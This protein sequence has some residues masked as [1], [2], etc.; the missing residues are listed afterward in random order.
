MAP[1]QE[2][3]AFIRRASAVAPATGIPLKLVTWA[4]MEVRL[5]SRFHDSS[6]HSILG[7]G[8]GIDFRLVRACKR[9]VLLRQSSHKH[10]DAT[11]ASKCTHIAQSI[12]C[13][14]PPPAFHFILQSVRSHGALATGRSFRARQGPSDVTTA[15]VTAA[16]QKQTPAAATAETRSN[17]M[18]P[19]RPSVM[20]A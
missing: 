7:D 3:S 17:T 20:P 5:H 6:R 1:L 19:K 14:P 8:D 16:A 11:N 15:V 18:A 2:P 4:Q 9:K 12:D 10:R 13:Y